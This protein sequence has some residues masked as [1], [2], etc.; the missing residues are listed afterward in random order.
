MAHHYSV[1]D[2]TCELY[3]L[4]QIIGFGFDY[5][6]TGNFGDNLILVIWQFHPWSRQIKFHRSI[7]NSTNGCESPVKCV[8]LQFKKTNRQ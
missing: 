6:I 5:Y 8:E 2:L 1:T 3:F 4:P 7:V